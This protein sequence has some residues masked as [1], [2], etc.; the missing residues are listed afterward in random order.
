MKV[1]CIFITGDVHNMRLHHDPVTE[2]LVVLE[3]QIETLL[4]DAK[5]L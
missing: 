4:L 1:D 2:K 5:E 3:K